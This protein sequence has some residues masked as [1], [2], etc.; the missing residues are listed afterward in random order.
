[1]HVSG[2]DLL[3]N[4]WIFILQYLDRV[5][6]LASATYPVDLD[7]IYFVGYSMGC[8]GS[9]RNAVFRPTVSQTSSMLT[10]ARHQ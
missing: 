10:V 6:A 7:R 4:L 3:T 8:R 2:H 1:M 9:L 5:L